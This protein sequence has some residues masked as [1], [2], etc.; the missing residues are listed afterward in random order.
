MSGDVIASPAEAGPSLAARI[1]RGDRGAENEFVA[2]YTRGV[3][4]L[5]KRNCRDQEPAIP[6]MVQD[7]LLAVLLRLRAGGLEDSGA[8]LRYI[9]QT[10]LH[11]ASAEYRRQARQPNGTEGELDSV[12]APGNVGMEMD[13]ARE[14]RI[15]HELINEMETPRDR[16]LL[17]LFYIEEQTKEEVC[18]AL[19]IDHHHFHRVV[20]RARQRLREKLEAAGL[21][22]ERSETN[23]SK[24][25]P[26]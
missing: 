12:P 14:K 20:F 23:R 9:Q 1:A 22:P 5:L 3:A 26:S 19:G 16:E 17:R 18:K 13:Q 10:A 7:A 25:T 6:D 2:K 8:L 15:L 24:R 4:A 21:R 11:M